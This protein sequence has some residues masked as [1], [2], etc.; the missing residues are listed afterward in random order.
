MSK[1]KKNLQIN[2]HPE[3]KPQRHKRSFATTLGLFIILGIVVVAFII[4]PVSGIG[5]SL[6][7]AQSPSFAKYEGENIEFNP[8]GRIAQVAQQYSRFIQDPKRLLELSFNTVLYETFV[9]HRLDDLKY[10]VSSQKMD[11]LIL[12][13]AQLKD[14]SGNFDLELYR[15]L[16][17]GMKTQLRDNIKTER[18][19]MQYNNDLEKGV[20]RSTALNDA[21]ASTANTSR[22][23][24][25]L[26][27]STKDYPQDKIIA[28][29]DEHKDLFKK[30]ELER[31][32]LNSDSSV[33]PEEL[34]EEFKSG[35]REFDAF[36]KE[37]SVD[38]WA[39]SGG[40]VGEIFAYQIGDRMSLSEEDTK[41]L[42]GSDEYIVV[43]NTDKDTI[44]FHQMNAVIEPNADDS[45]L[46]S[47]V[48]N[49]IKT[50]D[51]DLIEDYYVG[52]NGLF[53]LAKSQ[54]TEGKSFAD[55]TA[56]LELES[57]EL[58]PFAL[59]YGNSP[60]YNQNL[61]TVWPEDAE[62]GL[63]NGFETNEELLEP[64]IAL[65]SVSDF[66]DV[67]TISENNEQYF[68]IFQLQNEEPTEQPLAEG[69]DSSLQNA[70]TS[71]IKNTVEN[72]KS[73][74]NTFEKGY[75]TWLSRVSS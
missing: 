48:R 8:N 72:S 58:Q 4:V 42:L 64:L 3:S 21:I 24:S 53:T 66:S 20:F 56:N 63:S 2:R 5:F 16:S 70:Y 50:N 1:D 44:I 26:T 59:N 60:V 6:T 23:Y 15:G 40:Y 31:L 36:A 14:E 11:E 49:Y 9:A 19:T 35:T 57:N 22:T 13:N 52:E 73:F 46:I 47:Q 7:S 55:I 10:I 39:T 34:I 74:K 37:A 61:N 62:T 17:V 33:T 68:V 71:A 27:A 41:K 67:I 12:D 75:D 18:A 45:D 30:V 25:Y 54:L 69:I 65:T 28:Y 29:L 51:L 43:E 32:T 38:F